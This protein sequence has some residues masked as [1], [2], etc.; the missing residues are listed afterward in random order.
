MYRHIFILYIKWMYVLKAY[1]VC[2][3]IHNCLQYSADVKVE[4]S[5]V[6]TTQPW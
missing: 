5:Q 1:D 6:P 3:I 2:N 4:A